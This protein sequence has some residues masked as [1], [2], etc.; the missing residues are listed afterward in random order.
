MS[1]FNAQSAAR[2]RGMAAE[3]VAE[4]EKKLKGF[5][6]MGANYEDAAD[7]LRQGRCLPTPKEARRNAGAG[8]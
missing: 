2:A 4:A 7:L 5:F 3:K 8:R 6:G 1:G